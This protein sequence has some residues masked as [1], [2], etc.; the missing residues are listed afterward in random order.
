M[1]AYLVKNTKMKNLT[2]EFHPFF[3]SPEVPREFGL[4]LSLAGTM[5][6]WH[7]QVDEEVC[8]AFVVSQSELL[9]PELLV[10]DGTLNQ[11][12]GLNRWAPFHKYCIK[13]ISTHLYDHL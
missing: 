12:T 8:G 2:G 7:Y 1:C 10:L 9:C 3:A 11:T 6:P 13:I 5:S 4:L